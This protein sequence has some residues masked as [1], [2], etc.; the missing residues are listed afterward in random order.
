[1]PT[2]L[3]KYPA[4]ASKD[5]KQRL[6]E[7]LHA[8]QSDSGVRIPDSMQIE[9]LSVAQSGTANYIELYNAMN[10]SISKVILGYSATTDSTAGK[11]GGDN[12][13]SEVRNDLVAADSDLICSSFNRTVV[14]WLVEWN[15]NGAKLPV[16]YRDVKPALDLKAQVERDKLIFDMGY[17]PTLE[18]VTTTYDIEVEAAAVSTNQAPSINSGQGLDSSAVKFAERSS[19][20][21]LDSDPTPVMDY[22]DQLA[23]TAAKPIDD[24]LT[25]I[26][27]KIDS[28]TSLAALQAELLAMYGD[29]PTEDLTKV[30]SLAF[31]AADLAGRFE[32]AQE[33]GGFDECSFSFNL[34]HG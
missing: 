12:M 21:G 32:V 27:S 25:L 23:S 26:K 1:M 11:L 30:M 29:L 33:T 34:L 9:L 19:I 13:A 5:E 28:A 3:G 31:A 20:P 14:K 8:I 4:G 18:Y 2:A 6:L 22:T 10:A 17:K 15:F 7:A 16:V 24:W